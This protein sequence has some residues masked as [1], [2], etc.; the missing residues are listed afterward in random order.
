MMWWSVAVHKQALL[1]V[2]VSCISRDSVTGHV[3]VNSNAVHV[4]VVYFTGLCLTSYCVITIIN[5]NE[6]YVM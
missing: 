5:S 1:E 4:F 3:C 2:K 6:Y